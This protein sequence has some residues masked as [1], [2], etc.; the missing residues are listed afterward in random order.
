M[1]V[2]SG[3]ICFVVT[4][5]MTVR[6]F[7]VDQLRALSERYDLTL[8]TNASG[9][10]LL[11]SLGIAGR[12][13]AMPLQR[14]IHPRGD[15]VALSRLY[16]L[17]RT[18]RFCCVHSVTPKAGLLTAIAGAL[19]RVPN[20]LHTFTGQ[21][22]ATRTGM[23]RCTLKAADRAISALNTHVLADSG[24]QREFLVKEGVLKAQ[25]CSVLGKG[26]IGGVDLTRF[27]PN[28]AARARLRHSVGI[29]ADALVFLFVGRLTRDKGVHDLARAFCMVSASV[30]NAYL[31]IVGP[32]EQEVVEE[33]GQICH[34]CKDRVRFFDATNTPEDFMAAADVLSLPSYREGFGT[35]IVEAAAVGIPA[36]VSRIYGLMDAVEDGVTGLFHEAGDKEQIANRML[37]LINNSNAREQLGENARRRAAKHFSQHAITSQ[38][39]DLYAS[40]FRSRQRG[41]RCVIKRIFDLTCAVGLLALLSPVMGL[42]ALIVKAAMGSPVLFRQERPGK[43]A[44]LFTLLKFRTMSNAM[45]KEGRLFAD[46]RRLTP[47]GQFLRAT[48]L[49]ELPQLWNII[50]GDMSLVGPRPLLTQYLLRYTPEQAR[51]QDVMPGLTGLVQV[52]GRNGLKW[53][54]KFA[55]DTWYADHWSLGLDLRIILLTIKAV[56]QRDGISHSG[57]ATMP[58]FMSGKAES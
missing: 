34:G 32:D 43:S 4:E 52:C 33:L 44:K 26:S 36:V 7:L 2:H 13:V 51:R 18:E 17:F 12:T 48:S 50:R 46:E 58:E 9:S 29:P 11:E 15:L 42:V 24:S 55:V 54:Q 8:V 41:T 20:R 22:W 21:V 39:V 3:K 49:D 47:V 56:L 35:V 16:R 30:S 19:A 1:G 38:L 27:R 10:S 23:I 57:N 14:A 53:E 40:Q 25:K 31:W 5:P 6:A 28:R 45:D 37:Y